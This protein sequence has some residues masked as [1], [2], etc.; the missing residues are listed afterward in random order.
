MSL[1]LKCI[2]EDVSKSRIPDIQILEMKCS[3]EVEIKMDIHRKLNLFKPKEEITFILSKELPQYIEGK[4]FVA[5]GFIIAKKAE[6]N[7]TNMYISLWGFLIIISVTNE[8]LISG[9]N[10]MD[11]V[12]VKM[13][14]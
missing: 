5:H 12:Y 2:I 7:N 11:K 6:N 14:H 8:N 4:D 9:F 13:S 10:I 3:N 1:M